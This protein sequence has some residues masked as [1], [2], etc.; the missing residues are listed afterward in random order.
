MNLT[1]IESKVARLLMS[2]MKNSMI[3]NELNR[4]RS[5]ICTIKANIFRKTNVSTLNDLMLVLGD[6][7][8]L[9]ET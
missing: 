1:P 3:A 7:Q 6:S 2:G 8:V 9:N 5:T 4:D